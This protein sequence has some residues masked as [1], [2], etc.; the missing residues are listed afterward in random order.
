[1]SAPDRDCAARGKE[2]APLPHRPWIARAFFLVT[3]CTVLYLALMPNYGQARFRLVSLPVYRW[4]ADHDNLDNI[5]AFAVLA[6][7]TF[8]LGRPPA[9]REN[10]GVSDAFA[11]RF[12][13]RTA[14]LAGL[15]A[16]VCVFEI[17]Q[18]WIPGRTSSLVD[19][20]TGWS[21][22]FAAW[23]LCELRDARTENPKPAGTD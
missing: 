11:R 4:I 20:C 15:L 14:R 9:A 22:I 5:V 8:L 7:A 16:M 3:L 21:G 19:V 1:M 23:L 6:A 10:G 17:L 13:S 18:I 2:S 12:A